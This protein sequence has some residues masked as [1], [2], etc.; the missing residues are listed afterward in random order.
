M[1]SFKEYIS[2]AAGRWGTGKPLKGAEQDWVVR[3]KSD[4]ADFDELDKATIKKVQDK[5]KGKALTI[6]IDKTDPESILL[7]FN[8]DKKASNDKRVIVTNYADLIKAYE[9]QTNSSVDFGSLRVTTH[10]PKS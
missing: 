10:E 5:Y 3:I 9:K 8:D 4:G 7:N 6:T 1:K 2:E